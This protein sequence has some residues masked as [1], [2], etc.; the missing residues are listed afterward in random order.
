VFD[1][2][3]H[4]AVVHLPDP[5]AEGETVKDVIQIGYALGDR[6]LRAAKVA[7]TAPPAG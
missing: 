7:V 5:D 1:P 2:N 6:L 4:E 3:I